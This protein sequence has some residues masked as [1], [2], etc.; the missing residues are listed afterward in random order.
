[1]LWVRRWHE[2]LV[3]DKET[4]SARGYASSACPSPKPATNGV[5]EIVVARL[6]RAGQRLM[7]DM[8]INNIQSHEYALYAYDT[9]IDAHGRGLC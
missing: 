4:A 1:M 8:K 3:A 6:R 7:D 5:R 9:G 2:D